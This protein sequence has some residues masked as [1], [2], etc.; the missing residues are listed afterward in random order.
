MTP[1]VQSPFPEL[2]SSNSAPCTDLQSATIWEAIQGARMDIGR[3][4]IAMKQLAAKRSQL[5]VFVQ[6]N[7]SI[8]SAIRRLPPEIL[9]EIFAL[10]V[11]GDPFNPRR[12]GAWV[13]ARVCRRW[14]AVAMNTAE[15]WRHFFVPK[16]G[17]S[18]SY[19]KP[20]LTVQLARVRRARLSI[21]L[22]AGPAMLDL[23]DVLL[24][25]AARWETVA[26]STE[27]QLSRFT[28]YHSHYPLLGKLNFWESE[29]SWSRLT[30][31]LD[32]DMSGSLPALTE[33]FWNAPAF[34]KKL[35]LPWWQ[36]TLC[37]LRGVCVHDVQQRIL[38]FLTSTARIIIVDAKRSVNPTT[39]LRASKIRSLALENSSVVLTGLVAPMLKKLD[40]IERL[41]IGQD[42]GSITNFMNFPSAPCHLEH[43]R[44]R[45]SDNTSFWIGTLD[46]PVARDIMRLDISFCA[47]SDLA[48]WLKALART[49]IVPNLRT[50]AIRGNK[51]VEVSRSI[52]KNA[53]AARNP[54]V[55][56][57]S[58]HCWE[59]D[60]PEKDLEGGLDVVIL[61]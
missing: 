17:F 6:K 9:S 46:S 28:K 40:V 54:T 53:L 24:S 19:L 27:T 29:H 14:R 12:R 50:L 8:L 21:Q 32:A 13:V 39:M 48:V 16:S 59:W 57:E 47:P 31:P 45:Q 36:L 30:L 38:P 51:K 26:L 18:T 60:F 41:A 52:F 56:I 10:C 4:E 25:A 11:C 15:L 43:L 44:I 34:P 3:I 42:G 2:L 1:P 37:V 55:R 33:L 20:V 58:F 23:M 35:R 61:K 5:K 22:P 49:D 7:S